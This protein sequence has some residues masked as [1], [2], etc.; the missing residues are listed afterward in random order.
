MVDANRRRLLGGLS[1]IA[2]A[3]LENSFTYSQSLGDCI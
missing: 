2:G 3:A 1:A